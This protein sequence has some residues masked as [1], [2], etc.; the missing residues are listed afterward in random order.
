MENNITFTPDGAWKEYQSGIAFKQSLPG[1]SLF[2]VT[3]EN[4]LF[5]LGNQWLNVNAPSLDKPTF[6]ILKRVISYFVAMIS[7]DAIGVSVTPFNSI[8]DDETKAKMQVIGAQIN[9]VLEENEFAALG[10]KFLRWCAIKGDCG[11]HI[12]FSPNE[13]TGQASSGAVRFEIIQNINEYFGNPQSSDLEKQPYII[14]SARK[15]LAD[16]KKEALSRGQGVENIKA[17]SSETSGE[18]TEN[19]VPLVTVLTKYEKDESGSVF[20]FKCTEN[21]VIMPPT[22]TGYK[23]YPYARMSWE[24]VSS[25]CY[26]Q[27]AVTGLIPNQIAVNKLH[28]MILKHFK[29]LAFR[30]IVYDKTRIPAWNNEIGAIAVTGDVRDVVAA[31]TDA[32]QLPP[33][34]VPYLG[35]I[36][37][38]TRDLMGAS[39]AALG[40]VRPDNTS[41]IIALQQSTAMPLDL[42]KRGYYEFCERCVRVSL[43]II[44]TD[45]GMRE[46]LV[47][48][49]LGNESLQ[50]F[51]F[52]SLED[53]LLKLKVDIGESSYWSELRQVHLRTVTLLTMKST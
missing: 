7:S 30:K 48:D 5:V 52:S 13:A 15:P 26:G 12:F 49:E 16:V 38:R 33:S 19:P 31:A 51:D 44:K 23:L 21:A 11:L 2:D 22:D 10:K 27:A 17:D 18:S 53:V 9:E 25:C 35:E 6:N 36:I 40:N 34:I 42:Q 32:P 47:S 3:K 41:A 46:V 20:V 43:D 4:E 39:D 37:D 50:G 45:Y 1:G 14:L 8:S 28:A 29:D 24:E